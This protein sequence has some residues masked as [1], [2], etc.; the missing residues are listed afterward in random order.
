MP[1]I[2]T[3][4]RDHNLDEYSTNLIGS[5]NF[6]V[7]EEFKKADHH[8]TGQFDEYGQFTGT[9]RI[10]GETKPF[11]CNWQEGRGRAIK[12]GSF[13]IDFAYVMGREKESKLP[14]EDYTFITNKLNRIGGLYIYR[15]GIRILPYG[16]SDI[17]FLV[18]TC[19]LAACF[20]V[21]FV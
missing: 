3:E 18:F 10:Y 21:F 7:P 11:V 17:D 8:F 9:V 5:R 1:V 20:A 14:S 12:C 6:F 13:S 16:D 19:C 2:R 15:D 4:F